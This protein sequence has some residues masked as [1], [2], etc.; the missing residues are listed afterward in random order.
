M[1]L[2]DEL[3]ATSM[4]AENF[5]QGMMKLVEA[6]PML[7]FILKEAKEN[8]KYNFF[9]SIIM[10]IPNKGDDGYATKTESKGKPQTRL[11]W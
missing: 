5:K 10:I 4:E 3:E 8:K 9:N 2:L 7:A 11:L 1:E 6:N